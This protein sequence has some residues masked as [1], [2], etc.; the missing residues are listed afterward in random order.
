MDT[1]PKSSQQAF[2]EW[3]RKGLEEGR[4]KIHPIQD[5]EGRIL[6]ISIV[7]DSGGDIPVVPA[8]HDP[9]RRRPL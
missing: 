8:A 5:E 1:N 7:L 9:R 6:S 3:L 4:L 2:L